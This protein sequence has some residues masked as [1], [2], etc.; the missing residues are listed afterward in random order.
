MSWKVEGSHV[1]NVLSVII[2]I[3]GCCCKGRSL[4]IFLSKKKC[5]TFFFAY[6]VSTIYIKAGWGV[7]HPFPLFPTTFCQYAE[8]APSLAVK[9]HMQIV[10]V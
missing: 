3:C 7:I 9:T 8:T 2:L 4:K 5:Y 6:K 1:R 10:I